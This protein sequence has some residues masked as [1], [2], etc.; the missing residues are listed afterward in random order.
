L[1][2]LHPALFY[3]VTAFC[4]VYCVKIALLSLKSIPIT[5][6]RN[7]AE[8]EY[9]L[10]GFEKQIKSAVFSLGVLNCCRRYLFLSEIARFPSQSF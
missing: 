5:L 1:K 9:T 10:A 7:V 2:S 6:F 4:Y 8:H 3:Y